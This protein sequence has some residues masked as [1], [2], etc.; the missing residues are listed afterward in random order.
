MSARIIPFF[1]SVI[2]ISLLN[3]SN[4][5]SIKKYL[6]IKK[7]IVNFKKFSQK[8]DVNTYESKIIRKPDKPKT[9]YIAFVPKYLSTHPRILVAIMASAAASAK[10]RV[11]FLKSFQLLSD[12]TLC[13]T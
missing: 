12:S 10:R 1:K 2:F 3:K 8:N 5:S 9:K 7:S 11:E 6:T 4:P 13:Q